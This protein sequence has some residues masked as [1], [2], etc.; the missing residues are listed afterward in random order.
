MQAFAPVPPGRLWLGGRGF[1]SGA[2]EWISAERGCAVPHHCRVGGPGP[3]P[4]AGD[5]DM[6]S[7]R[8]SCGRGAWTSRRACSRGR[9]RAELQEQA[10]LLAPGRVSSV[11]FRLF[12]GSGQAPCVQHGGH[13]A[14]GD[15]LRPRRACA[16]G[17]I[18]ALD[19]P[20]VTASRAAPGSCLAGVWLLLLFL[21]LVPWPARGWLLEHR[22]VGKGWPCVPRAAVARA[23]L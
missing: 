11:A 3:L 20:A 12:V 8:S 13:A 18:T 19:S 9:S 10:P 15:V 14:C 5:K 17:L 23:R 2:V 21:G 1:V 7:A 6:L 4:A 22:P 16:A